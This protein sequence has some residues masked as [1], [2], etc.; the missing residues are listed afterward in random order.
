MAY[1]NKHIIIHINNYSLSPLG[2]KLDSLVRLNHI[3][4]DMNILQ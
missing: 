1:I 2:S 4:R 3:W